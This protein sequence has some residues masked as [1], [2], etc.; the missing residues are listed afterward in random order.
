MKTNEL[1][2]T[3]RKNGRVAKVLGIYSINNLPK[4]RLFDGQVIDLQIFAKYI[5]NKPEDEAVVFGCEG[6]GADFEIGTTNLYSRIHFVVVRV[7]AMWQVLD[8]SLNGMS[9]VE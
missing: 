6:Y 3:V 2:E 5:K 1:F 4:V 8:C 7:G 9:I